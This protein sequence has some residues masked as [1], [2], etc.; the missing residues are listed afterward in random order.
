MQLVVVHSTQL[1]M[2]VTKLVCNSSSLGDAGG[3]WQGFKTLGL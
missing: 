1:G 3:S 2:V